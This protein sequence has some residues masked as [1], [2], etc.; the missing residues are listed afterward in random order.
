MSEE[1]CRQKAALSVDWGGGRGRGEGRGSENVN[2]AGDC[3]ANRDQQRASGAESVA[4]GA[5]W[6]GGHSRQTRCK[7]QRSCTK[8]RAG[9][10]VA[11]LSVEV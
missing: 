8:K 4:P 7:G 3:M 9:G 6:A 10:Q 11:H 2:I 1:M 5:H